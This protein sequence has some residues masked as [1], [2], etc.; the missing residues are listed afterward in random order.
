MTTTEI[1]HNAEALAVAETGH[2]LGCFERI[3][4]ELIEAGEAETGHHDEVLPG[5]GHRELIDVFA[6]ITIE[7]PARCGCP[8]P[9]DDDL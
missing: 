2:T 3:A 8:E 6:Q 1:A 4:E 7:D 9:T 5:R